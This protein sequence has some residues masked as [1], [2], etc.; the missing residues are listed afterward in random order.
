MSSL[1]WGDPPAEVPVFVKDMV[2]VW[3]TARPGA[4]N[5]PAVTAETARITAYAVNNPDTWMMIGAAGH[6]RTAPPNRPLLKG[7]QMVCPNTGSTYFFAAH[8]QAPRLSKAAMT[9]M[10][11]P[12]PPPAPRFDHTDKGFNWTEQELETVINE[13]RSLRAE[14]AA[15]ADL[16]V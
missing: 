15:I 3:T 9:A 10:L 1:T 7:Q 16:N 5:N 2:D 12:D 11:N 14:Q 6:G 8:S 13:A 4:S